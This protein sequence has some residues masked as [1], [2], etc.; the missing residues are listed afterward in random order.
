MRAEDAEEA[1]SRAC[2]TP[3]LVRLRFGDPE[4][5]A[6]FLPG[7]LDEGCIVLDDAG[8][9]ALREA[10]GLAWPL[11]PLATILRVD[12]CGETLWQHPS[13]HEPE[14]RQL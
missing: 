2:G 8:G 10:S 6:A 14:R 4:T 7:C 12:W 5:G 13:F 9:F 1:L 11:P 3:W